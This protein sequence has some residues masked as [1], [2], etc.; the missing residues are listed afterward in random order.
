MIIVNAKSALTFRQHAILADIGL[1]LESL[2]AKLSLY[3]KDEAILSSIVEDMNYVKQHAS[4]LKMDIPF[5]RLEHYPSVLPGCKPSFKEI[6][7][8]LYE[9]AQP[10]TGKYKHLQYMAL[11]FLK[12]PAALPEYRLPKLSTSQR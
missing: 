1:C 2:T 9:Q 4:M 10:L 6:Y 8:Q 11:Q 3:T 12:D 5:H 7:Q